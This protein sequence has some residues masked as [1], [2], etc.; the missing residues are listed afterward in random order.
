MNNENNNRQTRP[1]PDPTSLTTAALQREI[2]VLREL[3]FEKMAG[4]QAVREQELANVNDKFSQ[5]ESSRV[6]QKSDTKAAVD[7]ALSAA[8][9][10][11]KEQTT[12][13]EARTDKSEASTTKSIDQLEATFNTAFEGLRR[14]IS[15]VKERV[16]AVEQQKK[17]G[18]EA[19]EARRATIQ[20][21]QVVII[22]LIGSGI[23]AV[24]V[25]VLTSGQ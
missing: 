22:G 20:P 23:L 15:D 11:V 3:M 2:T 7:A 25:A 18:Q 5:A 17:G 19:T 13:S 24:I 4:M 8:K 14:E 10:A 1:V 9:E 6:E 16:T 21:F 12:A